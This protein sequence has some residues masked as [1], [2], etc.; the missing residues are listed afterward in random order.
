MQKRVRIGHSLLLNPSWLF[1]AYPGI[2]FLTSSYP[3]RFSFSF[4][5]HI[6]SKAIQFFSFIIKRELNNDQVE[7]PLSSKELHFIGLYVE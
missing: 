1:D 2:F 5:I 3:L 6:H 7:W 4:S